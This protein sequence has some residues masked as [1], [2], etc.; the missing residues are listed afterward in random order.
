MF[1]KILVDLYCDWD[2]IPPTYRIFADNE[3]LAEREYVWND[4]V[5]V[6][7]II[8]VEFPMDE[9]KFIHLETV[10]PNISNFRFENQRIKYCEHSVKMIRDTDTR[11]GIEILSGIANPKREQ[12]HA[13]L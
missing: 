11:F 12:H 3:L 1:A 10:N 8:Q 5:Y 6:T 7:E 2:G 9:P 13:N 4:P